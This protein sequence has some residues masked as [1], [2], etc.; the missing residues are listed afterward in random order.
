[1]NISGFAAESRSLWRLA[2]PLIL[3]S[4]V[5][6]AISITDVIMMGWI[7]TLEIAAGAVASDFYSIIF[8][9]SAGIVA[10]TSPL[11]ASAIS[12]KAKDEIT[13]IFDQGFVVVLLLSLPGALIIWY[14]SDML[15]LIGVKQDIVTTAGA[16]LNMMA[17][18]YVVM[19]GVM[20]CHYI[21]SAHDDTRIIFYVT[22][23]ALPLNAI[24]NYA[25]MFG[26][27]GM[28]ELGLVGAGLSSVLV[29]VFMLMSFSTY[30]IVEPSYK[31]YR[32]FMSVHKPNFNEIYNILRVG[33]PIGLTNIAE[34]GVFMFSTIMMGMI[35]AQTLAAHAVA[36]RTAGLVYAVPLGLSQAVT[37]RVGFGAGLNDEQSIRLSS[38]TALLQAGLIG[39]VYLA[40]MCIY[41]E[42]IVALYLDAETTEQSIITM[43]L[44]FMVIVALMQP[45]DNIHTVSAGILRGIKDTRVPMYISMVGFLGVAFSLAIYITFILEQGGIGV[46]IGLLTGVI[47]VS[48]LTTYRVIIFWR[49]G[50]LY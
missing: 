17:G 26:H 20:L 23:L 14:G 18:T 49:R 41:S 6:M 35:D 15:G 50:F 4:V 39:F 5:S 21:I 12:R 3:S 45:F 42:Q 24:G 2:G 32:L 40:G 1:M 16:Y 10:A 25:F 33:I 37:I 47:L 43:A 9:F 29:T 11:F 13:N 7:G 22:F 27:Y 34:L 30:L 28:P 48:I 36:L 31:K 46:W 19:L 44:T 8:Y 38:S